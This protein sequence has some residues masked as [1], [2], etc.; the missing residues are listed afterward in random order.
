MELP[1]K[2]TSHNVIN[3]LE[4]EPPT[5]VYFFVTSSVLGPTPPRGPLTLCFPYRLPIPSS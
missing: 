5:K 4:K 2:K 3:T 1:L